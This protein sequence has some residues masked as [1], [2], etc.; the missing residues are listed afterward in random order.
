VRATGDIDFLYEQSA[1][2]VKRLCG[3]LEEFGA[4]PQF[5]DSDFMLSR[6]SVTQ[7]G[8]EPF[9]IDFL[10]SISGVSFEHV[11]AGAQKTEIGGQPLL[12]IGLPELRANKRA[13]GRDKDKLDL[14]LLPP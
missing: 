6:D 1:E 9:R 4:P 14:R 13:T 12:V 10:S 5:I 3:A 11:L 8:R 2:N 7:I